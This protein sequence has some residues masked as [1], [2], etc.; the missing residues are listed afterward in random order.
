MMIS[1][2]LKWVLWTTQ[3][4]NVIYWLVFMDTNF[5]FYIQMFFKLKNISYI[6]MYKYKSMQS[7]GNYYLNSYLC[8]FIRSFI[9]FMIWLC[10]V[11]LILGQGSDRVLIIDIPHLFFPNMFLNMNLLLLSHVQ[12]LS[13]FCQPLNYE[14]GAWTSSQQRTGNIT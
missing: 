6:H 13:D 5:L 10:P 8:E 4:Q 3:S 14:N 2:A 11:T 12:T 1:I 9:S 7:E